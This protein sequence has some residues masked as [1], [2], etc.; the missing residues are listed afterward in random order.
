MA[1]FGEGVCWPFGLQVSKINL[2]MT[3]HQS[4][5]LININIVPSTRITKC[6]YSPRHWWMLTP[7]LSLFHQFY[8][9]IFCNSNLHV[10]ASSWRCNQKPYI[11]KHLNTQYYIYVQTNMCTCGRCLETV[12]FLSSSSIWKFHFYC[13]SHSYTAR[14]QC[15]SVSDKSRF[16][17]CS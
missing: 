8:L 13:G 16:M 9:Y 14:S 2:G 12:S 4:S 5:K 1:A 17:I 15:V 6:K 10:H 11:R 3:Q 7:V